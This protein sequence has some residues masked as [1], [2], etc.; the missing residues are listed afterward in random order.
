MFAAGRLGHIDFRPL[1]R[2]GEPESQAEDWDRDVTRIEVSLGYRLV[3][4]AGLL[5]SAYQ[6]FQRDASDGDGRVIGTRLWWA[7]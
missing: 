7:F 2:A 5:L 1:A 6:Q 3:R 4:N